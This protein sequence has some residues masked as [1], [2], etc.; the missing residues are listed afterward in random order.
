MLRTLYSAA[1]AAL[2]FGVTAG[3]VNAATAPQPPTTIDITKVTCSDLLSSQVLDRAAVVMFY[4]GWEAAKENVT[5]F[6]TGTL[7]AATQKIVTYCTTH[8]SETLMNAVKNIDMR[9][10]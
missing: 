8:H 3:G 5:T 9:P 10:F 2:A 4:W 1:V 7:K 6:K